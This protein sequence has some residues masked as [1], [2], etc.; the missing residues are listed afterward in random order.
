MGGT[1]GAVCIQNP[2]PVVINGIA[3]P[4]LKRFDPKMDVK[5]DIAKVVALANLS[6]KQGL[7]ALESK[8]KDIPAPF[9]KKGVQFIVDGT[10][11]K[12]MQEILETEVE[13]H[14]EE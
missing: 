4:S 10:D 14:E 12:M 9:F 7:L 8:L 6:R 13:H 11:P 5:G 1:L 2:L 3:L